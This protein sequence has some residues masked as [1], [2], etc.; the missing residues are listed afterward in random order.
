MAQ[1][2]ILVFWYSPFLSA[3]SIGPIPLGTLDSERSLPELF[4]VDL[5]DP[6]ATLK[7][8]C[9][10]RSLSQRPRPGPNPSGPLRS[11]LQACS[12]SSPISSRGGGAG[13][14]KEA[15]Q[16]ITTSLLHSPPWDLVPSDEA[17]PITSRRTSSLT[18]PSIQAR[19][20]DQEGLPDGGWAT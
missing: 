14:K 5:D 8:Y 3:I 9:W 12:S 13:S 1:R 11:W 17:P 15:Q 16:R 19:A 7:C 20:D 2:Y 18:P 4:L 6:P 10:T